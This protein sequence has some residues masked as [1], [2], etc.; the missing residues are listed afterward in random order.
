MTPMDLPT[1]CGYFRERYLEHFSYSNYLGKTETIPLF[2]YTHIPSSC[3][4]HSLNIYWIKTVLKIKL[5]IKIN[6]YFPFFKARE[7]LYVCK[8]I[9]S[10]SYQVKLTQAVLELIR[11]QYLRQLLP[12]ISQQTKK[13]ST[14][15]QYTIYPMVPMPEEANKATS[16]SY[17]H[18][19][20]P[21]QNLFL[22]YQLALLYTNEATSI[23]VGAITLRTTKSARLL[24]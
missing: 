4:L 8:S 5:W 7:K 17:N 16:L 2:L 19:Y 24:H 18:V 1:R 20:M 15:P 6:T 21:L 3:S 10:S 9:S 11:L 23:L 12:Y 14:K 13:N 22:M